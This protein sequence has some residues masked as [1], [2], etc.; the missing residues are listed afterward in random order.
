MKKQNKIPKRRD[1]MAYDL[2]T[3]GLY[4][5]KIVQSKKVYNRKKLKKGKAIIDSLSPYYIHILSFKKF[6]FKHIS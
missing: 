6:L 2:L 4:K 1:P 5:Q 3:N